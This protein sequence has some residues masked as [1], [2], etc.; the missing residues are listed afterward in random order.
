MEIFSKETIHDVS[1]KGTMKPPFPV[2]TRFFNPV[3][4]IALSAGTFRQN[5]I[6]AIINIK[7]NMNIKLCN[8]IST[9]NI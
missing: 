3:I 5:K 2:R 1:K 4:T 9:S 8:N 7:I 6:T